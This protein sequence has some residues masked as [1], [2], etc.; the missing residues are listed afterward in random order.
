MNAPATRLVLLRLLS[1]AQPYSI[2]QDILLDEVNRL[3][4]PAITLGDLVKHLTWL[5][6]RD[7]IGYLPEPLDPDNADARKW[8]LREAGRTALQS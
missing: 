3:V 6:A 4:R 1:Y 5:K 8:H 2:P 7:M